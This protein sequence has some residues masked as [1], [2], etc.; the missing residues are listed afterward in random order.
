[1][2]VLKF[3]GVRHMTKYIRRVF[4]LIGD[5]I[6]PLVGSFA[7]AIILIGLSALPLYSSTPDR[8]ESAY[9]GPTGS[10]GNWP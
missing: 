1:M 4:A 2:I 9:A 8:P 7:A 10:Q 3:E 6:F 5:G